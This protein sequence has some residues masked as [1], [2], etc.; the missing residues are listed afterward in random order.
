MALPNIAY[1]PNT[2]NADELNTTEVIDRKKSISVKSN[3]NQKGAAVKGFLLA[4]SAMLLLCCFIYA[5][6]EV[7]EVYNDI[8]SAKKNIELM[9]SE[10]VR[11]QSELEAEMS[12]KNVEDYAENMLGLTKLDKSQ[13][14]Y[15]EVQSDSVIEVAPEE[16]SFFVTLRDK[17]DDL[18]EYILG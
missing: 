7:N 3:R 15:M 16:E 1:K 14:V 4:V 12:M 2:D 18:L 17:L 9:T 11:M 8:S 10:N 13:I 5:K 6:V